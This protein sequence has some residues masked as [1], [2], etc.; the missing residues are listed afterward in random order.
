M[1]K[2]ELTKDQR[3]VVTHRN[4]ALLVSAAAGSGKT[5]VL[6]DRLLEQICDPFHPCN[7]DE[8][9]IIT[10]TKAAASELRSKI[11]AEISNRL[12]ADSGNRHL[13][14]QLTRIYLA[15]ISTVHSFCSGLLR[16]YAYLLDIPADFR[17]AEEAECQQL[18]MKAAEQTLTKAYEVLADH[19]Q[20]IALL[21]TL[22]YGRDDRRVS[23]LIQA[24]YDN[25]QC[26]ARPEIW[27]QQ[28]RDT[29]ACKDITDISQ[30]LW[31]KYLLDDMQ[32]FLTQQ[33]QRL[34]SACELLSDIPE[35]LKCSDVLK[36]DLHQLRHLAEHPDWD[37]FAKPGAVSFARWPVIRNC[38]NTEL[39]QEVKQIRDACKKHLE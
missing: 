21:E 27:M 10:Y 13:R 16:S 3:S 7:V 32:T 30:T 11:A 26:H 22:G 12:A 15:E 8:F 35:L 37:H 28:C 34:Q 4:R 38:E 29:V 17:V 18:R 6:V 2:P 36:E 25:I 5:R 19:P 39:K 23:A 1:A 33:I 9:L 20:V 24:A 31:G 14:N